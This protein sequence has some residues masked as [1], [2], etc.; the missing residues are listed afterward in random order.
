A[1]PAP[2]AATAMGPRNTRLTAHR[3]KAHFSSLPT[4]RL[5]NQSSHQP[6]MAW[7]PGKRGPKRGRTIKRRKSRSS[8]RKRV[9]R[10]R[11]ARGSNT[12]AT[13][14]P[15]QLVGSLRKLA[16]QQ[17]GRNRTTAVYD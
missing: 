17:G 14:G 7:R 6:L 10:T 5:G 9:P 15:V 3:K 1:P 16:A 8:S 2:A 11:S 13:V 4:D 12:S